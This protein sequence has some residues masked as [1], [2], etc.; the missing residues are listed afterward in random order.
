MIS[1]TKPYTNQ[2]MKDDFV[3]IIKDYDFNRDVY[4]NKFTNKFLKLYSLQYGLCFNSC[5]NALVVALFALKVSVGDCVVVPAYTCR[6]ILDVLELLKIKPIFVDNYCDYDSSDFNVSE[7]GIIKKLAPK[8]KAIILPYMFG[9]VH[10]YAELEK[11]NIPIIEDVTLSLGAP[12][13][14]FKNCK[15]VIVSSFHSS[16]MISAN[17]GGIIATNDKNIFNKI[18]QMSDVMGLNKTERLQQSTEITY[19]NSFSFRPSELNFI[20]GFLQIS[21]LNKFIKERRRIAKMYINKLDKSKYAV[22]AYDKNN[23]YFRFIVG[24]HK[25]NVVKLLE[26]LLNNGIEAGRG[27]FPLLSSYKNN[28]GNMLINAEKTVSMSVSV[29]IYPGLSNKEVGFIIDAFN[30]YE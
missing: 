23:V 12:I 4:I 17:E 11:L 21:N 13:N 29:P 1:L 9:K 19:N 3:N 26:F 15:R 30:R 14:N 20:W 27:V 5:S 8:I 18:C 7:E 22:P 10:R 6:A 25:K 28:K 24:L 16:K 2:K